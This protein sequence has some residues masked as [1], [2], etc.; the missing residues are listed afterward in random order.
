MGNSLL[1]LSLLAVPMMI[2]VAIGYLD[3][4]DGRRPI[5]WSRQPSDK[6]APTDGSTRARRAHLP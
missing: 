3:R 5:E 4:R 6:V 1:I 2:L